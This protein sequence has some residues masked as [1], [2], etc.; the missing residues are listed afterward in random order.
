[1]AVVDV[2]DA[3]VSNRPYKR[4]F[5]DEEAV[6]IITEGSGTHFD[7]KIVEAFLQA[8]ELFKSVKAGL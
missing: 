8:K 3:L 7:P 4:A 6:K 5:S 2:Y 1:M